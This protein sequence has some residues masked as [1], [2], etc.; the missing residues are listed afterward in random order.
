MLNAIALLLTCQLA[1]EVICQYFAIPV[2]GPVAG[3]VLMIAVFHSA[4]ATR[5]ALHETSNGILRHLSLLFV[6]AGVGVMLHAA[7]VLDE[8]LAIVVSLLLGTAVTLMA[9][10]LTV[11]FAARLVGLQRGDHQ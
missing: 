5:D 8:W 7:T 9:T 1:G 2:P 11:K 6:P 4:P 3:M 10:A